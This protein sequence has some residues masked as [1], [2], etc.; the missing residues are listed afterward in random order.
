LKGKNRVEKRNRAKKKLGRPS[1]GKRPVLAARLHEPL[2]EKIRLAAEANGLSIS[3]EA[4]RRLERSFEWEQTFGDAKKL[5]ADA[6]KTLAKGLEARMRQAGYQ[7]IHDINGTV[8]AEPGMQIGR[9]TGA[10]NP[11]V[12]EIIERVVARALKQV[13]DK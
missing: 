4:E 7:P 12:E 5:M 8:W 2:H 11:A 13:L 6:E 10:I 1:T 9:F 3:E